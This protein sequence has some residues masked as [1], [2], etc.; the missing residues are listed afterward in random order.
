MKEEILEQ[1]TKEYKELKEAKK[2]LEYKKNRIRQLE[3]N[4]FVQEYLNLYHEIYEIN[5]KN[6]MY[7][8]DDI[9][10][11]RSI[12]RCLKNLEETNGIYVYMGTYSWSNNKDVM[13]PSDEKLNYSDPNAKFRI[14][15]D[16]EK[17]NEEIVLPISECKDFE[18]NNTVIVLRTAIPESKIYQVQEEFL[19][20][21]IKTNQ[22]EAKKRVL[23][24]Y[25]HL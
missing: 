12:D 4:K 17:I 10:F 18:K 7:L 16:L 21:A 9:L 6:E 22:E 24:K 5:S 1:I 13:R 2:E 3:E 20:D 15:R 14:Y 19:Q 11:R 8:P 23:R 25:K